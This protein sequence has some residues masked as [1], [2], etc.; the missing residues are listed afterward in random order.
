MEL[1]KLIKVLRAHPRAYIY[2]HAPDSFIVYTDKWD[3]QK[4]YDGDGDFEKYELFSTDGR[5]SKAG[6]IPPI[7]AALATIG[8]FDVGSV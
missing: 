5:N 4:A 7:V 6:L 8:G 2:Y 1:E 3:F